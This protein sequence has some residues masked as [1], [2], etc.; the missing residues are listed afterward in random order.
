MRYAIFGAK[1]TALGILK[2]L[3][4]LYT[5]HKMTTFLV[6]SLEGNPLVLSGYPVLSV[7]EFADKEIPVIVATPENLHKEISQMLEEKGFTN[8]VCMDSCKEQA[9]M[10]RYYNK[11]HV[12]PS[13]CDLPIGNN[14]SI[15]QVYIAQ[16]HKDKGLKQSYKFPEWTIPIQV[17]AALTDIRISAI[18]DDSGENISDRNS[19]YCELTALYWMWKNQRDFVDYCGLFHYRRFLEI[20]EDDILRLKN[21]DVDVILPYPMMCEPNISEHHK[22]YVSDNEWE[23]MI[24]VIKEIHPE[25][26][27]SFKEIFEKSYM[28]NYNMFIAKKEILK[29]FCQ[30][31][32]P[33]LDA[34]YEKSQPKGRERNDRYIGY[35]G[36]NLLTLYFMHNKDKYKIYHTKRIM[37][38]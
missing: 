16:F 28:Y 29:N 37:L 27:N 31:L 12:F 36:E 11:L 5:E 10:E 1:S 17:G 3:E 9:L 18:T 35:I 26:T 6:S 32:F 15:M 34:I 8:Y 33:I 14:T 2:A 7:D 25:Y 30:W 19:N 22:R 21:N 4:E 38:V 23:I 13:L 24:D 20:A